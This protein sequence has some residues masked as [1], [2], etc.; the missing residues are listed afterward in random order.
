M[1]DPLKAF[2]ELIVK[3]TQVNE[4][5]IIAINDDG[6]FRVSTRLGVSNATG[7]TNFFK[8]GD[9]VKVED[10]VITFQKSVED[11]LI[12]HER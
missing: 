6:T 5:T 12:V 10:G 9:T 4:G 7:D 11:S 3:E 8:V 1:A 2:R